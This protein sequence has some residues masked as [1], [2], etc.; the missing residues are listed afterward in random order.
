MPTK[1]G[2]VSLPVFLWGNGGCSADGTS[3]VELLQQIA[4]YGYLVIASGGPKQSGTTTAKMMTDSI[5]WVIQNAG[6]GAYADVDSKKI[7][8]AGY[9]CGG[10]E[11]Y[12]QSWDSRVATVGIF[13]SGFLTNYTAAS[14]FTNPIL[15]VLGG[16]S[17]IAYQNVSPTYQSCPG[18]VIAVAHAVAVGRERLQ[19]PSRQYSILEREPECRPRRYFQ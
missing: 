14:T 15:Y 17:D 4:S 7:M 13:S 8:V 19:G 1:T 16:T 11:A 18:V 12:A 9:S 3:N 10:I 6:K 2:N 5:D